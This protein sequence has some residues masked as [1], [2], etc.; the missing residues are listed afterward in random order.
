MEDEV[1]LLQQVLGENNTKRNIK[2][3]VD[4]KCYDTISQENYCSPRYF[5]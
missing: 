2:L 5:G 1:H 3:M 4:R